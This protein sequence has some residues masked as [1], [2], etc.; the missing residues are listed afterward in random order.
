[1]KKSMK[2]KVDK[3][4][5]ERRFNEFITFNQKRKNSMNQFTKKKCFNEFLK[6]EIIVKS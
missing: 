5:K 1:M 2:R 4:L 3:L 6:N